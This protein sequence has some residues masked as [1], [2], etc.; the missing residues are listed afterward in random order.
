MGMFLRRVADVAIF[1]Q[2]HLCYN[3]SC[4]TVVAALLQVDDWKEQTSSGKSM[5]VGKAIFGSE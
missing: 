2:A 3:A 1:P 4:L 5:S